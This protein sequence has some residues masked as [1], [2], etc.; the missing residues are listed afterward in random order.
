MD[1]TEREPDG[2]RP[3]GDTGATP[4]RGPEA[5]DGPRPGGPP[6]P[7]RGGDA[8]RRR[9]GRRGRGGGRPPVGPFP[10]APRV[11]GEE[12]EGSGQAREIAAYE[13]RQRQPPRGQ[14]RAPGFRPQVAPSRPPGF[15]PPPRQPFAGS[16]P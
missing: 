4:E 15:G 5:A 13:R 3:V 1:E 11:A 2:G 12:D 16:R 9:R 10:G 7:W 14:W 6:Q 8:G